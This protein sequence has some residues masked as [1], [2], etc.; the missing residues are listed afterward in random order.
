MAETT[1][2]VDRVL[3]PKLIAEELGGAIKEGDAGWLAYCPAHEDSNQSLLISKPENKLLVHC[4]AGCSQPKVIKELRDRGL[5][6][7]Q[8]AN[9]EGITD[10]YHYID[11]T[12]QRLFTKRRIEG[13]D[14]K[15]TFRIGT[16]ADDGTWK[17]GKPRCEP[18]L[19]NLNVL[20][21]N[22][23]SKVFVVEGEKDVK[24]LTDL[25][26]LAVCNFDGAGKWHPSYS[27]WLKDRDVIIIPDNDRAGRDHACLVGQELSGVAKD[28]KVLYIAGLAEKEDVSDWINNGGTIERFARLVE[29]AKD[30]DP[31]DA[32][33]WMDRVIVNDRGGIERCLMNVELALSNADKLKDT[34]SYNEFQQRVEV[35]NEVPWRGKTARP[36]ATDY[37]TLKYTSELNRLGILV[38]KGMVDDGMT[39]IAH[40]SENRFD[41]LKEYLEGLVWDGVPRVDGMLTHLGSVSGEAYSARVGAI[42][43][44]GAAARGL[45]GGSKVDT[46]MILEGDQGIYKSTFGKAIV[47]HPDW[48][49][50]SLDGDLGD[51]DT[52]IKMQGRWIIELP[53]LAAY[54]KSGI[55]QQKSFL[56]RT[57]DTVRLPYSKNDVTYERRCVFFGTHNPEGEGNYLKDSSGNRRQLPV[58]MSKSIDVDWVAENRDNLWAES[59]SRLR[60]GEAWWL[61]KDDPILV[62][63]EKQ[64]MDRYDEHEIME[65]VA[66]YIYEAPVSRAGVVTWVARDEPLVLFFPKIFWEELKESSYAEC[67]KHIKT[68]IARGMRIRKWSKGKFYCKKY[69]KT[70]NGWRLETDSVGFEDAN[71]HPLVSEK[72][73][74]DD[75]R[76]ESA[77]GK[78]NLKKSETLKK[79]ENKKVGV[80]EGKS[81]GKSE[82][83]NP[84]NT[85]A[86]AIS[87][88]SHPNNINIPYNTNS[89]NTHTYN[90]SIN[91]RHVQRKGCDGFGSEKGEV[92]F[93]LGSGKS[94]LIKKTA[95]QSEVVE[96]LRLFLA[97]SDEDFGIDLE[98]TGL[99]GAWSF[100]GKVRLLQIYSLVQGIGIV[101]D[102]GECGLE[103]FAPALQGNTFVAHNATFEQSFIRYAGID[104]LIHDTMLAYGAV[105]GGSISL[106]KL[107]KKILGTELDKKYQ[108]G[109]WDVDELSQGQIDYAFKDA[110]VVSQLWELFQEEL[111]ARQ[112]FQGYMLLIEAIPMVVEMQHTGMTF[113]TDSHEKF[114]AKFQ[115]GFDTS[116]RYLAYKT[117]NIVAN[118]GSTK[119]VNDWFNNE[120]KSCSEYERIKVGEWKTT[121]S[122]ARS[123]GAEA[124]EDAF[125][126]DIV[127]KSLT[128][129]FRAFSVRQKRQKILSS[130]GTSL[131]NYIT[132]GRLKGFFNIGRAKTSR[133]SS[134]HPNLQQFPN[135]AFRNLF[136]AAEG[137]K[138]IICDYS[139]VEV[140]VLAEEAD[141]TVIKQ[142]FKDG[143]DF[144]YA[145]ASA[146]FGVPIDQVTKEQRRL[147]KSL[148]FGQM[149]GMGV[150]SI[151]AKLGC[152]K[153]EAQAYTDAWL[154]GYP[155]VF[156]WREKM[157]ELGRTGQPILTAGGRQ[158]AGTKELAPSQ[159]INYPVQSSAADV[160][161]KA[162][163]RVWDMKADGVKALAVV[164]D[165]LILECDEHLAEDA[166]VM[167]EKAMTEGFLD[168]YPT[169]DTTDLVDASIATCW[170]EK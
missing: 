129:V 73:G 127:P 145:T 78:N 61:E 154:N 46:I 121:P 4:R 84:V 8:R 5:W 68:G 76:G 159:L 31:Q 42:F 62:E 65:E 140:R 59:V 95:T 21:D 37:D 156:A 103:P 50:D 120:L 39:S 11:E 18:V 91:T 30:F 97:E 163:A 47:P 19:F 75:F 167:L 24:N 119:Q 94:P 107:A 96:S 105:R 126:R 51:K 102:V 137:K 131:L 133:M 49:T 36:K 56:A 149:Y 135:G 165:E 143:H 115:K 150:T 104:V 168:I 82:D 17:N 12:G 64:Q 41:P 74:E 108:K 89:I 10:E 35:S 45:T 43:M 109:G 86:V 93:W 2:A 128:K 52:V 15:K 147:S 116:T 20:I 80:S 77:V 117:N 13:R 130:F 138:L 28:V 166:K 162:M 25:G 170:G 148:T 48:F 38:N 66:Q 88:L 100:G 9:A 124:I 164:H 67:G 6:V 155:K 40:E 55:N 54:T 106:A 3:T 101:I 123:Y 57:H 136:H 153:D 146:M 110:V 144:H 125:E 141:E 118:W 134:D 33:P 152:S 87:P 157:F 112:V 63:F 139:Q 72:K 85:G 23:D 114:V 60:A 132:D 58:K 27:E 169:A 71:S 22:P 70:G 1:Q 53:E 69:K 14:G 113:D 142:A 34:L 90:S 83:A 32:L 111:L 161:Y 16:Y 122:G 26:V 79:P 158:I 81:E 160:L 29:G 7:T 99:S 98:T 151:A 92:D 44:I